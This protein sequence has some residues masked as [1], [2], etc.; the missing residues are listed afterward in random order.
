MTQQEYDTAIRRLEGAFN[1]E[2]R[3]WA[4]VGAMMLL[5][6]DLRDRQKETP[7]LSDRG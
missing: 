7:D 5:L 4:L 1:D 2:T 3:Y 6:A